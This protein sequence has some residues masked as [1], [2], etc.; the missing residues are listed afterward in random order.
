V[1]SPAPDSLRL[2]VA[3]DPVALA[4]GLRA[5]MGAEIGEIMRY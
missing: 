1:V 3:L 2:T 5:A 4:R